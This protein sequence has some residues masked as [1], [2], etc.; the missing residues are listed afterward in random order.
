MEPTSKGVDYSWARPGGEAIK[1]EGFEFAIR[2][3]PYPGDTG[4]GLTEEEVKD[5]HS[6]GLSIGLVFESS[7]ERHLGGYLAGVNDANLVE[8]ARASL[9]FPKETAIYFAVDFDAQPSQFPLIN[10]YQ[11]GAISVLGFDRVGMYGHNRVLASAQN[12]DTAKWFWQC[13]AWS[14]GKVFPDR[15]LY[16]YMNGVYVNGGAVDYNYAYGPTQGLWKPEGVEM[17]KFDELNAA[18]TKREDIRRV[19]SGTNEKGYADMLKAWD[20]LHKN[21]LV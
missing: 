9:E 3:V 11:R 13:L 7:A 16:Q 2:Y 15:H 8:R 6:H 12:A 21:G 1:D 10:E 17:D 18:M 4:K 19:A 20:L 5:L 14:G